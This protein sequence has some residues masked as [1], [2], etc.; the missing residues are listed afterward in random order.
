MITG[1]D[2]PLMLKNDCLDKLSAV[3]SF[4]CCRSEC[5]SKGVG[6]EEWNPKLVMHHHAR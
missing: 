3:H 4:V 5:K 6:G 2:R 1:S